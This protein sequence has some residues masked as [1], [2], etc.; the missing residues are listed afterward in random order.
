MRKSNYFIY[1]LLILFFFKNLYGYE[2]I[3]DPI[4]ENY[5]E[6]LSKS[7]NLNKTDVYLVKN[8]SEN[9][10]V[11]NNNIYFTTGLFKL[12]QIILCINM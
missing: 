6:K 11:I 5:F 2:I 10:F 1:I 8:D 4:I 9:A 7:L 12:K 3:R